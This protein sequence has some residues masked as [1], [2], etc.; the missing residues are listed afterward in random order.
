MH[1]NPG[2]VLDERIDVWALVSRLRKLTKI[3]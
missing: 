3:Y 1:I 2:M